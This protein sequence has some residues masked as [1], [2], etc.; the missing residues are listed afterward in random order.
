M[1]YGHRM[2][3]TLVYDPIPSIISNHYWENKTPSANYCWC[4]RTFF[5]KICFYS[6]YQVFPWL[7]L[8][9]FLL[10]MFLDRRTM[11]RHRQYA[12]GEEFDYPPM[13]PGSFSPSPHPPPWLEPPPPYEVAI[14]TTCSST[15][16]RRAY[17]DTHLAMEPL[18]GQSR[19]ISFEVWCWMMGTLHVSALQTKDT[20]RQETGALT[21]THLMTLWHLKHAFFMVIN[22]SLACF[23]LIL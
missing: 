16:L 17:S 7:F 9:D 6:D 13:D 21:Q 23:P 15:H 18:F 14:K 4:L 3:I 2:F 19:E 11:E 22:A 20:Y 8:H 1:F 5:V 12:R 10:K